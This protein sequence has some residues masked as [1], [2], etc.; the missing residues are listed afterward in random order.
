ML[1]Y[2]LRFKLLKFSIK[3][4]LFNISI[5][6]LVIFEIFSLINFIED[7]VTLSG[8]TVFKIPINKGANTGSM[9]PAL[10]TSSILNLKPKVN[11]KCGASSQPTLK[12]YIALADK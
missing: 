11:P 8:K 9:S 12:Q 7:L 1:R 5:L 10:N 6:L 3:E 2:L 4:S